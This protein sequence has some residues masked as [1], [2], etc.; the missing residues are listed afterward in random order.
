MTTETFCVRAGAGSGVTGREST[1]FSVP[2][3]SPLFW[4]ALLRHSRAGRYT[5]RQAAHLFRRRRQ[6]PS[7][8]EPQ[9]EL[10]SARQLGR[11]K[12]ERLD[13]ALREEEQREREM[14]FVHFA[15]EEGVGSPPPPAAG[16]EVP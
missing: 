12:A 6:E 5:R 4:G 9:D 10:E 1:R 15:W 7:M 3:H 11:L 13:F 16:G 2:R 14:R 8:N